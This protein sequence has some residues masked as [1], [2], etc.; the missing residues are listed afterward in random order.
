MT[1]SLTKREEPGRFQ[2]Y[3]QLRNPGAFEKKLIIIIPTTP[4][5]E[6]IIY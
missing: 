4:T 2:Y 5:M 1:F 6:D 3:L